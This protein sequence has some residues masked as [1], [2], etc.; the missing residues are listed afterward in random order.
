MTIA[1]RYHLMLTII[2]LTTTTISI[3][4]IEKPRLITAVINFRIANHCIEFSLVSEDASQIFCFV[5]TESVSG[6]PDEKLF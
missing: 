2:T 4:S 6:F 5:I 3:Q 1:E